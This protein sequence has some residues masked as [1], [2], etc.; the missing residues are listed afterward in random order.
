MTL[1]QI[2][3]VA[4]LLAAF[5]IIVTLAF[6]VYEMRQNAQQTRLSNWNSTLNAL[7]EHKRRTDDPYVA[8]VVERGRADFNALKSSEQISFGYWMEEWCQAMEGL[9]LANSA[10]IHRHD[11]MKRAALENYNTMFRHLGCRQWW[12]SSGLAQ[13]WPDS[14]VQAIENA[15][16]KAEGDT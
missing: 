11:M 4:D 6:L 7:R 12:R 3:D 2:A 14:L 16:T 5:G 8:D 10:S 9:L 15:I 13:R 1:S